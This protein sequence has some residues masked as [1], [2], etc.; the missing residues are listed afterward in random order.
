MR[1]KVGQ[2]GSNESEGGGGEWRKKEWPPAF[3]FSLLVLGPSL[4]SPLSSCM[5]P[6]RR[7]KASGSA[8]GESRGRERKDGGGGGGAREGGDRTEG[9]GGGG[10]GEEGGRAVW[11]SGSVKAE[12]TSTRGRD[13]ETGSKE[14]GGKKKA[15]ST[16]SRC[17]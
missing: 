11:A 9:E 13:Y 12:A 16:T 6:K 10:R 17:C 8:G 15:F 2:A 7:K 4:G 1:E 14:G 5:R 3:P